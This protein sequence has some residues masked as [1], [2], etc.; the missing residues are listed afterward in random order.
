[1]TGTL[2]FP[3]YTDTIGAGNPDSIPSNAFYAYFSAYGGVGYDPDDVNFSEPDGNDVSPIL[4]GFMT[5]NAATGTGTYSANNIYASPSPNP[6]TTSEP[7]PSNNGAVDT[8]TANATKPRIY[9]N[10]QSFQ[11]IS[12]GA[13][14]STASAGNTS[15]AGPSRCRITRRSTIV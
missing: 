12:P 5:F 9:V 14:G 7:F 11:I 3:G 2:P 1:M 13:T 10:P 4:G 8:T 6:Y 15:R